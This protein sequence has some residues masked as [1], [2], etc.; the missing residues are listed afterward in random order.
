MPIKFILHQQE[1]TLEADQIPA[2]EALRVLNLPP[3][4]YLMV[5]DGEM[6]LEETV[7][8]AGDEIRLVPVIAGG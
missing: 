3:E 6:I 2:A 7:L 5:R 8:H 1:L 4:S